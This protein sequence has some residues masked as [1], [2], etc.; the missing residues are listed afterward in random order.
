MELRMRVTKSATGSV[1]LILSPPLPVRSGVLTAAEPA[2][3]LLSFRVDYYQLDLTTPGISPR[4][5][6]WR[7]HKRHRPN[8]RR[9]ARGRPQILQRLCW[10]LENF[11]LRAS[12]TRFAVVDIGLS[13][14]SLAEGYAELPQ[15]GT[16]LV[17]VLGSGHNSDIHALQ[18]IYARVIHLGENQ[19]V[20]HAQRVVASPVEALGRDSLEV[21]YSREGDGNQTVKEFVH[22]VAAQG[23]H[24]ANRHALADLEGGNRL[25]GLG[26]DRLL[27]GD[28]GQIGDQGIHD[29]HVL[30]GFAQAHVEDDLFQAG[31]SHQVVQAQFLLQGGPNFLLVFFLQSRV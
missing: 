6:S 14:R 31:H 16:R 11:G 18:L 22:D 26:G 3:M 25:L 21:A 20:A 23:H 4:S 24:G 28:R 13:L 12:L 30:R 2:G 15:Q 27:P 10:R 9:Y 8:L 17:I 7:K 1:K 29:L 5:A 19:L